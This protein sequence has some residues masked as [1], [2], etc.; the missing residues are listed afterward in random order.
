MHVVHSIIS[1][2]KVNKFAELFNVENY[3]RGNL[4]AMMEAVKV[5]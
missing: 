4:F 3:F 5:L 2:L 1:N